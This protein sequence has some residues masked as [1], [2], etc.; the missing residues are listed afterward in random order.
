MI[1]FKAAEQKTRDVIDPAITRSPQLNRL[2]IPGV[3]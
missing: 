3:A 2:V 1:R